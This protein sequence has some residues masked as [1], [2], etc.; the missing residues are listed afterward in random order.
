M[1]KF[2]DFFRHL[3]YLA[4]E[5]LY[6]KFPGM[7]AREL[8]RA[9]LNA[10]VTP[11]VRLV[12][13][14]GAKFLFPIPSNGAI[15][16]AILATG[17]WSG[18]LLVLSDFFIKPNS[19]IIEVGAN[20]GYESAYY[21][22][23]YPNCVVHAYEPAGYGYEKVLSSKA[24]NRFHNLHAHRIGLSDAPGRLTLSVPTV[25]SPNK[26]LGSFHKNT[27]IDATY[28]TEEVTVARLDDH[29]ALT[30]PVSL[31]KIDTQGHELP[32]FRGAAELISKYLPIIIFEFE[33]HYHTEPLKVRRELADFL[34]SKGYSTFISR[35]LDLN[36]IDLRK[37]IKVHHDIIALPA[38]G[39]KL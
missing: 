22:A 38:K 9:R 27:D 8:G 13:F 16:D 1:N 26:G 21:A 23:K 20:I 7:H 11:L 39:S 25:S 24:L 30:H 5:F 17:N 12:D 14:N 15:E 28:K 6:R 37:A 10:S 35:D 18:D 4:H 33:D 19:A 29:L 31:L 36:P 3:A 2:R 32:V 34:E